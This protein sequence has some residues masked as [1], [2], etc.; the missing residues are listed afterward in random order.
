[1]AYLTHSAV[2][3]RSSERGSA[4][5][6]ALMVAVVLA[7][8]GL[9]LLLQ[10][11]LGQQAAGSERHVIKSLYAADAG[12]M[13]QV[14]MIRAGQVSAPTAPFV[15]A[16]DPAMPGFFRGRYEVTI[17]ANRLCEAE[18]PQIVLGSSVSES[19]EENNFR[20]RVIHIE[21]TAERTLGM[22]NLGTTRATVMADVII[23]P[24]DMN[25]AVFL[26]NCY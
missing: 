10:T 9:G 6:L 22:G 3:D 23:W 26:P 12:I 16:E 21:S 19:G 14:A 17:P 13:M 20:K 2:T 25:N 7:A 11:S 18:F 15:L 5:I 8:L 1:M 24:F 4:L